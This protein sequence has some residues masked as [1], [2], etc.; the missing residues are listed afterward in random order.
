MNTLLEYIVEIKRDRKRLNR[1]YQSFTNSTAAEDFL[2]EAIVSDP[3]DKYRFYLKG[4][5]IR[6]HGLF[7]DDPPNVKD[8]RAGGIKCCETGIALVAGSGASPCWATFHYK[9]I[10]KCP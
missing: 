4:A 5:I 6:Q 7:I 10:Q 2:N 8:H 1:V 9:Q 3:P